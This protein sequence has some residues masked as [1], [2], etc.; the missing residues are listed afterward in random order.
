MAST[1]SIAVPG[2]SFP[3]PAIKLFL[4]K[5]NRSNALWAF[6]HDLQRKGKIHGFD[7]Y[8]AT[9][10]D[11]ADLDL[12]SQVVGYLLKRESFSRLPFDSWIPRKANVVADPITG[13]PANVSSQITPSERL[14]FSLEDMDSALMLNWK[15][16]YGK[17]QNKNNFATNFKAYLQA[18][19]K[20]LVD[21]ITD[22]MALFN[23]PGG[24]T[25]AVNR[26]DL[27]T[28]VIKYSHDTVI[29]D[30]ANILQVDMASD[31][32]A[33][34]ASGS[35]VRLSTAAQLGDFHSGG[36]G[37]SARGSVGS[38][39]DVTIPL[40]E[41][42]DVIELRVKY[43]DQ[44]NLNWEVQESGFVDADGFRRVFM[45]YISSMV[46]TT[47]YN[48]QE[49]VQVACS[50]ISKMFSLYD[51]SFVPS[52]AE[53]ANV[54][55]EGV[56]MSDI[57]MT[58][59]GNNLMGKTTDAIFDSF[60]RTGLFCQTLTDSK[61]DV[62]ALQK[63]LAAKQKALANINTPTGA[64]GTVGATGPHVPAVTDAD[65]NAVAR[66]SAT[67]AKQIVD[68]TATINNAKQQAL[69]QIFQP[70]D[71]Q[72]ARAGVAAPPTALDIEYYVPMTQ[73]SSR[74]ASFQTI[75]LI[76]VLMGLARRYAEDDA[77]A[78]VNVPGVVASISE[79]GVALSANMAT[80]RVKLLS[81]VMATIEQ[82][83][84]LSY[85]AMMASAY[86][87]FYPEL[88]R[89]ADIFQEMKANTYLE[90]F[91]DRPGVV[92]LRAPKYNIINLNP[93]ITEYKHTGKT[94]VVRLPTGQPGATGAAV[95]SLN[96]EYVIPASAIMS[97]SVNRDD[98]AIATRAD[99]T[100]ETPFSG[101][102]LEGF[103]GHF[104][105]AGYLLKY[106]LRTT[107]PQRNP[108]SLSPK[109]A[110]VL[111]A[112]R[113][114]TT[115]SAARTISI[116]VFNNREYRVGRLYYIP[117]SM[118]TVAEASASIVSKGV[119]GYI[120]KITTDLSYSQEATHTLTLEQVRQADILAIPVTGK[121]G[122]T[123][124]YA[125]F[126]KLPDIGT[127]MRLLA[128]NDD[129]NTDAA[130]AIQQRGTDVRD[131]V[132][133]NTTS[134]YGGYMVLPNGMTKSDFDTNIASANYSAKLIG[135]GV[136]DSNHVLP[137]SEIYQAEQNN[138]V[139]TIAAG[140]M[141]DGASV[142]L[143]KN[144]L[145]K[146]TCYDVDPRLKF[147]PKT[148]SVKPGLSLNSISSAMFS[149]LSYL[150]Y[151]GSMP[152]PMT[153]SVQNRDTADLLYVIYNILNGAVSAK[154]FGTNNFDVNNLDRSPKFQQSS[155]LSYI[156]SPNDPAGDTSL[157]G[158]NG[159]VS[160]TIFVG[161]GKS[162]PGF[163][164]QV[165][166]AFVHSE[167]PGL[168]KFDKFF[169]FHVPY[170]KS[171]RLANMI[172][173]GTPPG[174]GYRQLS[175]IQDK[176]TSASTAAAKTDLHADGSAVAFTN[177]DVSMWSVA[178]I[179]QSCVELDIAEHAYEIDD[180]DPTQHATSDR[181]HLIQASV[182]TTVE[183]YNFIRGSNPTY[184]PFGL[185]KLE[186]KNSNAVDLMM[187]CY[188]A[189]KDVLR[190]SL[191]VKDVNEV[192]QT[193]TPQQGAGSRYFKS[194][195][196]TTVTERVLVPA[197]ASFFVGS[198]T[199][200]FD[201]LIKEQQLLPNGPVPSLYIDVRNTLFVSQGTDPKAKSVATVSIPPKSSFK[202]LLTNSGF[203]KVD[204]SSL[205]ALT[206]AI[207]LDRVKLMPG[208]KYGDSLVSFIKG[209]WSTTYPMLLIQLVD[210]LPLIAPANKDTV[211]YR[212][213]LQGNAL[214]ALW[215]NTY[216]P[217]EV[218]FET[219]STDP[220]VQAGKL[221]LKGLI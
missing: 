179:A 218:Q 60:M 119:V 181:I 192:D 161:T 146:L 164:S 155:T 212:L 123:A 93:D 92:R 202:P 211:D 90:I 190:L 100:F 187:A 54:F 108:M 51:T 9:G 107:G 18:K 105:D 50:G 47:Q 24:K 133:N 162:G 189:C 197:Q 158:P 186:Y 33:F 78:A 89:P 2:A 5:V 65:K 38:V 209:M 34:F 17:G 67:L 79:T 45:G 198:A 206:F 81:T 27:T 204:T 86:K 167:G 127:Y 169:V 201:K 83:G 160:R 82:A 101:Q 70:K 128:T 153:E 193:A 205:S 69:S 88:K 114:A 151:H 147:Y 75:N 74:A 121:S 207:D 106:G 94:P 99:H 183:P 12:S 20:E 112:I 184:N 168:P 72:D 126:K 217:V 219:T 111:S 138:F 210:N 214:A 76:P 174:C 6:N 25:K 110:S 120:T 216:A 10:G 137:G 7:S 46:R 148:F 58:I 115:N 95:I 41:E 42:N 145:A 103:V 61:G 141:Q 15:N 102:P 71:F 131:A 19:K 178:D 194:D 56:E 91:E 80:A 97:L 215:H 3:K 199:G 122:V 35:D 142:S 14:Y 125:N 4:Y 39:N 188:D 77:A 154:Y 157:R 49:R 13:I 134:T 113:I 143:S 29:T 185:S 170:S 31:P 66:A 136:V 152:L 62:P 85:K 165:V 150:T 118:P 8:T 44:D 59:W 166:F 104:T 16:L 140:S 124:Y 196:P 176:K 53:K 116:T 159:S 177:L 28:F 135:A 139:T 73:F 57:K 129:F 173:S 180:K 221:N 109:I 96:A 132:A 144:F 220:D 171:L 11:P 1:T 117:I 21:D 52:L 84:Y 87:M 195:F 23:A 175:T 40:I 32:N 172:N 163:A 48:N 37:A 36:D 68:L 63:K 130:K 149:P 203:F 208:G 200:Y 43:L 55:E 64:T 30:L 26:Y 156:R 191:P 213:R 182:N 98:V 22:I